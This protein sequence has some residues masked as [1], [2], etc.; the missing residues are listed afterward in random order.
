MG[1]SGFDFGSG[2]NYRKSKFDQTFL[3]VPF[4]NFII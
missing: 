2:L 4:L 3:N 1:G